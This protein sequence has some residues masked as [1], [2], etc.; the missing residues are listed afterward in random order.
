MI[1]IQIPRICRCA[2]G[3]LSVRLKKSSVLC[4]SH[5][6]Q[7]WGNASGKHGWVLWLESSI[8]L[9]ANCSEVR[10]CLRMIKSHKEDTLRPA[11]VFKLSKFLW[12]I[13]ITPDSCC[14]VLVQ[15]GWWWRRG[16]F[17]TLHWL[18]GRTVLC[19]HQTGFMRTLPIRG[20]ISCLAE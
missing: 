10:I 12:S 16:L 6:I 8:I 2:Q 9:G 19:E 18:E 17:G 14:S 7:G 5:R 15:N 11:C 4:W 20:R 13:E 1:C 3:V